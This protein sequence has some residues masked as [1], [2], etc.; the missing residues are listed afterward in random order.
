MEKYT[1][2]GDLLAEAQGVFEKLEQT[3]ED[4]EKDIQSK[5]QGS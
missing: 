3:D 1:K 5:M 2:V 4:K